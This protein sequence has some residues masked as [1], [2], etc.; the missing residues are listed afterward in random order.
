M[1]DETAS[2]PSRCRAC[3]ARV[4]V[5][6]DLGVQPAGNL[7]S[8]GGPVAPGLPL[9]LGVCESCGLAQLADPSPPEADEPDAPSPLSSAT[10]SA[11][12]RVF[13]EELTAE[14][15]AGTSSR[16]LSLASHGGHLA[17]FLEE[18]GL[19]VIVL[20]SSPARAERG[21]G[22]WVPV[23]VGSLDGP[24]LPA[25]LPA[26]SFDLVVDSYL[27][28][29][30]E[31]PD[32]ALASLAGLLAPGG[33]LVFEFD[34]LL[35][36]VE[37]GQ[38]DAVR[39][40]HHTYLALGW[41]VR[42][43]GEHGMV[44]VDAKPQPVYGGALRVMAR[45]NGTPTPGVAAVLGR[46]ARAAIDRAGGLV[47]LRASVER[48][49][50]EVPAHLQAATNA[51]RR[52]VGYGAPARAITFLNALGIG[53]DLLPYVVD[54]APAKQGRVIPGVGIPIRPPEVL[55]DEPPDELLILTWDLAGEVRQAL[56]PVLPRTRFVVAV[57]RLAEVSET[58]D[59]LP[60]WPP[61]D[62]VR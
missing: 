41:L 32:A 13:V 38:W 54:R 30:L 51:G 22:G 53:P 45:A 47:P 27:L 57:P 43:L 15:L 28:A 55:A 42:R 29:H 37:G 24:R 12:A 5:V 33:A 46:E 50:T 1:R 61:A 10:M 31:R 34:H 26:A 58:G 36:T 56:A 6:I 16:I 25:G 40:G 48:A 3:E 19:S 20:E 59:L 35:A 60:G 39:H 49:R 52:V 8:Q 62:A 4:A 9:R 44:V 2:P 21:A 14:G 23:V 18:R 7:P 11:H 17:P